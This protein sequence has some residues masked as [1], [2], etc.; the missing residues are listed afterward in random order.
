[1]GCWCW[2][3]NTGV[4]VTEGQREVLQTAGNVMKVAD[5]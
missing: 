5:G 1:M 4:V 3:H 2:H